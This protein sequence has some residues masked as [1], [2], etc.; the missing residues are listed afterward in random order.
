MIRCFLMHFYIAAL[1][2]LRVQNS[3]HISTCSHGTRPPEITYHTNF[4]CTITKGNA[5]Y[6]RCEFHIFAGPVIQN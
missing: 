3:S 2:V 1:K 6:A 5:T 4:F